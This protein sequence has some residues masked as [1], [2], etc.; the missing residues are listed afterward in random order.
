VESFAQ[1][2]IEVHFQEY[3]HPVYPQLHGDFEPYMSVIDLLFNVGPG[4][5][6]VMMSGNV[7]ALERTS[8]P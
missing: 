4:S 6:E 7:R 8:K 3:R 2:G 1:C 5:F